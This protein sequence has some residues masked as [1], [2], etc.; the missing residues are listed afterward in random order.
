VEG[1]VICTKK[2]CEMK[3]RPT[4]QIYMTVLHVA[5]IDASRARLEGEMLATTHKSNT[6][7][8]EAA[9]LPVAWGTPHSGLCGG[10]PSEIKVSRSLSPLQVKTRIKYRQNARVVEVCR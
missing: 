4:E 3:M 8:T 5:R 9:S 2:K 6:L 1:K 7:A 10:R